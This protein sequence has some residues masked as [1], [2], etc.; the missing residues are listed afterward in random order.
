[1][2]KSE[3]KKGD[4]TTIIDIIH[5]I[6]LGD[7]ENCDVKFSDFPEGILPTDT[8]D[9][10]RVEGDNSDGNWYEGSTILIIC[11]EREET[12]EENEDRIKEARDFAEDL[13]N[14][15]RITYLNFRREFKDE[16]LPDLDCP[17]K[18]SMGCNY[19][20]C[21]CKPKINK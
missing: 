13:K 17:R 3:R 18:Y 15:R 19:G 14:R 1:M 11:R 16:D 10:I 20:K 9:V 21:D 5:K 2:R 7:H 4:P 6:N 8:F 12:K